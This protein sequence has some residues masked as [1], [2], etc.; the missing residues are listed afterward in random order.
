MPRQAKPFLYRGWFCT[1]AGGK[2]QQKLCREEEGRKQAE[3][4]LAR[5]LVRREDARQEGKLAVPGPGIQASPGSASQQG[6]GNYAPGLAGPQ[7]KTV[8]VVY[9]EFMEAKKSETDPATYTWYRDKLDPFFEEFATRALASIT[10]KDGITY[11]A[12]LREEK[13]WVKGKTPMKGLGPTTVNHH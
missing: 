3:L 1:N 4:A 7:P 2:P 11:K 9:D 5:L 13:P 8:A 12:W 10:Y 6:N